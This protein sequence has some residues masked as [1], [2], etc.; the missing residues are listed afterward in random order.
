MK[1]ISSPIFSL[2][3]AAK[4]LRLVALIVVVGFCFVQ[5]RQQPLFAQ[6]GEDNSNTTQYV[7]QKNDSLGK[8]AKKFGID[9]KVLIAANPQL[10]GRTV[11]RRGE[12]LNIPGKTYTGESSITDL[13]KRDPRL[14]TFLT[15]VRAVGYE[16][17]FANPG[18]Y[19]VFAPT[20]AAFAAFPNLNEILGNTKMLKGLIDNHIVSGRL[21]SSNLG[22]SVRTWAGSSVAVNSGRFG[23]AQIVTADVQGTNGVIHVIDAVVPVN[24]VVNEAVLPPTSV[25]STGIQPTAVPPTAVPPTAVSPTPAPNVPVV[26]QRPS[27]QVVVAGGDK[28]GSLKVSSSAVAG[29]CGWG[30]P[31][32]QLNF[33]RAIPELT[34]TYLLYNRDVAYIGGYYSG[35]SDVCATFTMRFAGPAAN[36]SLTVN[37]VPVLLRGGHMSAETDADFGQVDFD[38]V[39][40]CNQTYSFGVQLFSSDGQMTSKRIS[41]F[42]PCP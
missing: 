21:L 19:T 32:E 20:N 41:Q 2:R 6:S 17:T 28:G 27:G 39:L 29:T 35:N 9:V 16:R 33:T 7:V 23:Y 18:K 22:G 12:V 11:I 15:G 25:P 5:V 10:N 34:I 13:L 8:I 1:H 37:S 38:V 30:V 42:V 36:Y 26:I 4:V 3:S 31:A 40:N 24:Q 14:S